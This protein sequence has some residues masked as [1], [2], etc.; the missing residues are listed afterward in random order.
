MRPSFV[1]Q[2]IL[3]IFGKH[4]FV[5]IVTFWNTKFKREKKHETPSLEY[6]YGL[7]RKKTRLHRRAALL[8]RSSEY[9]GMVRIRVYVTLRT[10]SLAASILVCKFVMLKMSLVIGVGVS[11]VRSLRCSSLLVKR[12]EEYK[13]QKTEVMNYLLQSNNGLVKRMQ[14][15]GCRQTSRMRCVTFRL[16][17]SS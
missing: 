8:T 7:D 6:E 12:E 3:Y 14:Q 13:D 10:S 5:F 17:L 4:V 11:F 16:S 2:R 9:D 15:A 1:F